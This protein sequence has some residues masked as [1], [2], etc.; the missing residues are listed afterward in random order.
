LCCKTSISDK[1]YGAI[2]NDNE[3]IKVY[4]KSFK[5]GENII[6]IPSGL[7]RVILPDGT[8]IENVTKAV[9]IR[10]PEG[11]TNLIKTAYPKI[12]N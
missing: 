10:N 1:K 2:I 5:V 4:W 12:I 6:D 9:V 11:A 8:I 7:G 3:I